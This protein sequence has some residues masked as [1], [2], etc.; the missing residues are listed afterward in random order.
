MRLRP[1]IVLWVVTN[2]VSPVI[3][4]VSVFFEVVAVDE[5]MRKLI[6]NQASE[7]ELTQWARTHSQSIRADGCQRVLAGI[8]S[9]EEVLRVTQES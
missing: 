4:G 2:V 8:T 7:A 6:H 5:A 9:I 1:Y 3:P